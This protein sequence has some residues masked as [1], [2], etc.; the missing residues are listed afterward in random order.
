MVDSFLKYLQYERNSSNRTIC[1]YGDALREFESF[2]K[3]KDD[4]LSWTTVDK[5]NIRDWVE[6]LMDKGEK[7][8]TINAKLSAIRSFYRFALA[9]K[10]V[11]KDP[12]HRVIGPKKEKRLPQFVREEEMDTLL[13]KVEWQDNFRDARDR[14]ILMTFYETGIRRAELQGL[15]DGDVDFNTNQLKV[16][17]K[18]NKQRIVPFGEELK[19]TLLNYIRC[20]DAEV[21]RKTTALFVSDKGDRISVQTVYLVV[22]ANLSLVSSANKR[23]PHVLRHSFATAML[24]HEAG[25][26]SVQKLLGHASLETTEIYTHTTFEQLKKVYKKAHPRADV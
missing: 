14:A 25:L 19:Q 5:D 21:N 9:R 7:A 24:N 16:T 4:E 1:I 22:K 6:F 10:L 20:R 23:S 26:E 13:D 8:T 15:D 12:A 2:F 18:R 17:G 3:T 11:E